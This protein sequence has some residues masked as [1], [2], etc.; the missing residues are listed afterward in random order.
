[1]LINGR[2]LRFARS[3]FRRVIDD[4][5]DE[6]GD[7]PEFVAEVA[8]GDDGVFGEGL[9]HAGGAAAEDAEAEG[10]GAVFG[11]EVDGVDDVAL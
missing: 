8:A 1:M 6:A 9:V 10:V 5:L 3:G 11:D 4:G 7:V 2:R